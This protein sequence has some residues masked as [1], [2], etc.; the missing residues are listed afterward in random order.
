[1]NLTESEVKAMLELGGSVEG[2]DFIPQRVLN[3]LLSYGLIYWRT[4]GDAEFTP[5][6]EE[7][8]HDLTG[9]AAKES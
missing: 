2:H 9:S 3:D 5:E 4:A 1:M 6:G 7:V 8:Y